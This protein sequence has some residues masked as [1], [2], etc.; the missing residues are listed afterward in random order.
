[1]RPYLDALPDAQ[2]HGDFLADYRA[3]LADLFEQRPDGTTLFPFPR[4]FMVAQRR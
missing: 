1:L 3:R 4:L 2:E